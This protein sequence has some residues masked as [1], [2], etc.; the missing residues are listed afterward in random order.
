MS[1]AAAAKGKTESCTPVASGSFAGAA[2]ANSPGMKLVSIPAGEFLIGSEPEELARLYPRI[3]TERY[4][5]TQPQRR[6]KISQAFELGQ[7]PVTVREFRE[8]VA[9]TGCTEAEVSGEGYQWTG[10]EWKLNLDIDWRK[11]G[12]VQTDEHP[13]VQITWNNA[14]AYCEWLSKKEGREY[15]LPTEAEWEYACRAGSTGR[16][17]FGDDA[18]ML[19]HYAWYSANS[20]QTT[21]P[22]GQKKPNAWGLYDMHG[23][24]GE[25]CKD[26][27]DWD[28]AEPFGD[29]AEVDPTGPQQGAC[30]VCRGGGWVSGPSGC[31]A[32]YRGRLEPR[33]C[34]VYLGFRV[35]RSVS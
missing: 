28:Y 32:S 30:R 13:I 1:H 35:V 33:L 4:T 9:D 26:W 6:V 24:V 21:H 23:N 15:R 11:P 18:S 2:A 10:T 34:D 20:G 31:R 14:V 25:W 7:Y 19:E 16:W 3:C 8:F 12:F 17:C 27:W 29:T 5:W 22:V